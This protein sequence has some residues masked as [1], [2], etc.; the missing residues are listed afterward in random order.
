MEHVVVNRVPIL[1]QPQD[2]DVALQLGGAAAEASQ[3]LRQYWNLEPP[4]QYRIYVM[5]SLVGFRIH[6]APRPLRLLLW[7]LLPFWYP[8]AMKL[9][10]RVSALTEPY[11][12]YPAIGI[13]PPRL[14]ETGDKSIGEQYMLPEP[15]MTTRLRATLCQELMHVFTAHLSLPMWLNEGL[16]LLSSER[17]LRKP[18]IRPDAIDLLKPR[19]AGT[20]P[21][22]YRRISHLDNGQLA[23]DYARGYYI[24]RL[25]DDTQAPFLRELL[26]KRRD[27]ED[28]RSLIGRHLPIRRRRFW[29]DIDALLAQYAKEK[30]QK[31][32]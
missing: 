20:P 29:Q 22:K 24:T 27:A 18:I 14:L 7:L 6:A 1:Y 2:R 32:T 19:G 3:F 28:I 10:P 26:T 15:D 30:T 5:D 8:S 17:F 4:A 25:L 12:S 16:A 31:G 13:K 23:Y 21:S 9:W 11:Q